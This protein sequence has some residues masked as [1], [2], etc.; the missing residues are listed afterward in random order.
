MSHNL[1]LFYFLDG[2]IMNIPLRKSHEITG[3]VHPDGYTIC[4]DCATPE[5][6]EENDGLHPITLDSE[7][8]HAPVCDRCNEEIECTVLMPDVV[9]KV[10][11][12]MN[13][14]YLELKRGEDSIIETSIELLESQRKA[15]KCF[16]E[17]KEFHISTD[18]Y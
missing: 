16:S 12:D 7:W 14:L 6:M 3:Y 5:E 1:F 11:L 9:L 13:R 8:D 2:V 17:E 18:Y 10:V 15:L 4:K